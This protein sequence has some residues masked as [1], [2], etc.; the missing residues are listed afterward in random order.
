MESAQ[1]QA[2]SKDDELPDVMFMC[3][4]LYIAAF[5]GRTEEVLIGLQTGGVH[6]ATAARNGPRRPSPGDARPTGMYIYLATRP[7]VHSCR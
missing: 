4:E 3:S 2:I 6:T 5:E 1:G 7:L